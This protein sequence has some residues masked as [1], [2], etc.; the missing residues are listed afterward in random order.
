MEG[1]A[2]RVR[3]RKT[4]KNNG[5]TNNRAKIKKK[6]KQEMARVLEYTTCIS[7]TAISSRPS[8][9]T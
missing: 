4:T 6:T 7:S 5:K 1:N 2:K 9:G 3:R 8:S